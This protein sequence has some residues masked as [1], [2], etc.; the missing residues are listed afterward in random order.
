MKHTSQYGVPKQSYQYPV[1]YTKLSQ[2]RSRVFDHEISR[3]GA[4]FDPAIGSPK[5]LALV[6]AIL[7]WLWQVLGTE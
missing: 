6:A 7:Q 3:K 4:E 5:H 2:Q 1:A